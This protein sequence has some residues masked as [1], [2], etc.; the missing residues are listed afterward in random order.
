M[1]GCNHC[2]KDPQSPRGLS[3]SAIYHR[4]RGVKGTDDY[5]HDPSDF[6]R[7]LNYLGNDHPTWMRGVSKVWTTYVDHWDELL[8]LYGQEKHQR[9]AP[10]LYSR[11][12][13][14]VEEARRG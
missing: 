3:A 6:R 9:T 13:E 12:K 4:R 8:D 1:S 10:R 7:C 11:M 14:L 5:P 2:G